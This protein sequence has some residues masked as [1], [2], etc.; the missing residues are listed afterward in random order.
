MV[1][2]E[3]KAIQTQLSSFYSLSRETEKEE[4]KQ[5]IILY[6]YG[7]SERLMSFPVVFVSFSQL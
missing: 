1:N 2:R 3:G 7:I 4:T 6:Y 5:P